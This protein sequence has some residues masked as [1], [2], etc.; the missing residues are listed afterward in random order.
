[1][2]IHQELIDKFKP[3]LGLKGGAAQEALKKLSLIITN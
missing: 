1:M 2:G 3:Y